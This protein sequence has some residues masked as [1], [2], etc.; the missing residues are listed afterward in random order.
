MKRISKK[1]SQKRTKEES[2]QIPIRE[3][4][5]MNPRSQN[6]QF[7][8]QEMLVG[9]IIMVAVLVQVAV[10]SFAAQCR[11]VRIRL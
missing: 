9:I 4:L 5:D 11:T 1:V 6:A 8:V 10:H 2:Y 3:L 7:V